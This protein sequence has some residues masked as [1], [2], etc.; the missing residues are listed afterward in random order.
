MSIENYTIGWICALQEEYE[1]AC[2][3]MDR[4]LDGPET[5]EVND[6]NSYAFGC[7]ERHYVVV[8]CLP[9]GRLGTNP[10]A[11]VARDMVRSFPNLR[12]ALMVGIGGGAPTE[13]SDIRLGDVVVS[14]PYRNLGGVVQYDFG[15]RLTSGGFQRTGQLNAP[16]DALL[17]VIPE[18]KRRHND[19]RKP[20]R[21]AEHLK[22]MDDMQDYQ[23]PWQDRLYRADYEHNGGQNCQNCGT[24]GLEQRQ[25]R[26]R[27]RELTIHYGTIASGNSVIKDAMT[28]DWYAKDPELKVLCFEME[29]AGLM[30][31]FPC[32]VIRG[33]CDYSDSHKNDDWHKYAALAAAAYAREL[34]IVLKPQKVVI[35]PSWAAEMK[36]CMYN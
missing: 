11:I 7:I 31:N 12:F 16:P 6:N 3:M 9:E 30:N 26:K 2:R 14:V 33:I 27:R 25:E 10:A 1:A 4:E 32:L 5:S 15:K 8:G 28:R 29:A 21:V 13:E 22:R 20:D 17:G 34:L 19:P 18:I 35:M 36:D 23:R 24:D